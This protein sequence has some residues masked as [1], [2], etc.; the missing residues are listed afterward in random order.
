MAMPDIDI[1]LSRAEMAL[2]E[3][4][5]LTGTGFWSAV[6]R[7]KRNPDLVEAYADRIA[8]ID[9]AAFERWALLTVPVGLGTGLM[10]LGTL[11]GVVLVG[12]AYLPEDEIL[13]TI[14]FYVGLGVLLVS[15]HGL[16]HLIVGW[17]SGMRFTHWFIGKLAQPQPGVK[18][19]YASYLRTPARS[20]AMMHAAG[21]VTTKII[22][23]LLIGA[24]IA[25]ELPSWAVWA[26]PVIGLAT[27]V[28][29]VAW[30]TKKSDWAK[31]RRE[32]EFAQDP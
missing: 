17:G 27:I 26:L 13:A 4:R 18:V 31:Y 15:T 19:D 23:F 14:F 22:P 25:A 8:A 21:A 29:D 11:L 12:V 5:G 9:R 30:S 1:S 7:V 16:A 20:R 3:G 28:T 32:M 10:V 6:D 24:A 2:T